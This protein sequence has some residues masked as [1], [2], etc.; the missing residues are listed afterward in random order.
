MASSVRR[1]EKSKKHQ[2][3]NPGDEIKKKT[4]D[5]MKILY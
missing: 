4:A 5:M 2:K 3:S 1:Q